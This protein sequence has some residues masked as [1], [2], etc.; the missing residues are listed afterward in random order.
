MWAS[1]P[2]RW[3]KE[4]DLSL[5]YEEVGKLFNHAMENVDMYASKLGKMNELIKYLD[6]NC[7]YLSGDVKLACLLTQMTHYLKNP[8]FAHLYNIIEVHDSRVTLSKIDNFSTRKYPYLF[9]IVSFVDTVPTDQQLV[10]TYNKLFD[11]IHVFLNI[12]EGLKR[13]VNTYCKGKTFH[14]WTIVNCKIG[15]VIEQG[16]DHLGEDGHHSFR[17]VSEGTGFSPKDRVIAFLQKTSGLAIRYQ[18]FTSSNGNRQQFNFQLD[19]LVNFYMQKGKDK[20]MVSIPYSF[21]DLTIAVKDNGFEH[22]IQKKLLTTYN[23]RNTHI[24]S[25][26]S[27]GWALKEASL[28]HSMSAVFY[29]FHVFDGSVKSLRYLLDLTKHCERVFPLLPIKEIT[30]FHDKYKEGMYTL[31]HSP[32]YTNTYNDNKWYEMTNEGPKT[33]KNIQFNHDFIFKMRKT[34]DC[35]IASNLLSFDVHFIDPLTLENII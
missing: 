22:V 27:Y 33:S 14:G 19:C 13:D 24:R 20:R 18:P 29:V 5:L 15:G 35:L 16:Y 10:K 6:Y 31:E 17:F 32:M 25:L 30:Q 34:I 9:K 1:R 21:I 11:Y 2:K 12:S 4:D 7:T 8:L 26:T 3:F 28:G 23:V